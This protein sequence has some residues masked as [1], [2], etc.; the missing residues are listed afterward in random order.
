[1][2]TGRLKMTGKERIEAAEGRE[3]SQG[4]KSDDLISSPCLHADN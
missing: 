4:K 1:M 2:V 3:N